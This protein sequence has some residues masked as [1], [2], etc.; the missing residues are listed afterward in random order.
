M[1]P[2]GGFRRTQYVPEFGRFY[3]KL[4]ILL[5]GCMTVKN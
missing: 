4:V 5:G 2:I 1:F 3:K